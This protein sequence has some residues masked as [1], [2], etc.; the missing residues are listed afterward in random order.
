[1]KLNKIIQ[2]GFITIT[3]LALVACSHKHRKGGPGVTD[4]N[5]AGGAYTQGMNDGSGFQPSAICNIPQIA[6]FNTDPFYF[7]FNSNSVHPN[8]SS[9]IQ[10]LAQSAATNHTHLRIVGN[11][12]DRGSREYNMALGWRRANAVA[13]AAQ[14]YGVS[15]QQITTDSNG[16][17]K[18]I[19]LGTSEEDYQCNRRVDV[20]FK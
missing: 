14:Q 17:E 16:A 5:A 9:R 10:S 6:G 7:D 12:D 15:K 18:P 19:A 8:D 1:M 2:I 11:T 3:A 4:A 13:S 20:V